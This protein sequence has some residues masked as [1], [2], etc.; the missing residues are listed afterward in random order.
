VHSAH[1]ASLYLRSNDTEKYGE[2]SSP[3][4]VIDVVIAGGKQ[5]A[6]SGVKNHLT[7]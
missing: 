6:L 3:H 7:G 2:V 4:D 5:K 1:T